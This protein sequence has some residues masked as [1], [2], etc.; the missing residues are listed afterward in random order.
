VTINAGVM[1]LPKPETG[2]EMEPYFLG[3]NPPGDYWTMLDRLS[4]HDH[5][6]GLLGVPITVLDIPD[7][8]ITADDLHPSVLAPYAL[9]DGSKP[10][11]GQVTMQADAVVRDALLFG[12]QGTALAPDVT[13]TRTA[14]G[15]L[16]VDGALTVTVPLGT[17]IAANHLSTGPL[18]H[19]AAQRSGV[20]AWYLASSAQ[21]DF[22]LL[23][24]SDS[25]TRLHVGTTGTLSLTPDSGQDSI[26]AGGSL[27]LNAAASGFVFLLTYG[28]AQTLY[29]DAAQLLPAPNN[30]VGL[31]GS[32]NKWTVVWATNGTI[33]TS[34]AEAKTGI[35]PLDP[36]AAL[37]AVRATT[38]VTFDYLAPERSA[39]AYELPADPEQAQAVLEQRLRSGPLETAA[40]HQVGVV[41]NDPT[42]PCDPMFATGAGQTNPSNS[43]GILLAALKNLDSRLT[44]LG[45]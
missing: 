41:L 6:G 37:A 39:D 1:Q 43:V 10:F 20:P 3:L 2:D 17:P 38:P 36:A 22:Q 21:N 12:E 13:L 14:A 29:L 31:G 45:A 11:T 34:L 9:T 15:A 35:T 5:S 30:A 16:R 23:K 40:R 25:T 26:V 7:G 44:S 4:A 33:Q 24:G 27:R 18:A 19:Y 8:S 28:G 42:H 32:A